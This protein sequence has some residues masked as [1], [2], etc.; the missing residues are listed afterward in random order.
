[1]EEDSIAISGDSTLGSHVILPILVPTGIFT[2][3]GPRS[4]MRLCSPGATMGPRGGAGGGGGAFCVRAAP[5]SAKIA[6]TAMTER[7]TRMTHLPQRFR[8]RILSES[9]EK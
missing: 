6:T 5:V 3:R 2:T 7:A 8:P 9:P 1:M 4:R